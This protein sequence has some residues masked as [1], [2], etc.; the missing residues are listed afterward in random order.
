[1]RIAKIWGFMIFDLKKNAFKIIQIAVALIILLFLL[2]SIDYIQA[3]VSLMHLN[4]IFLLFAC[5]CYFL[6]NI[7]MSIRLKKILKHLG[8]KIRFRIV[9]LSHMAGMLLSDF[10]PGRS[11]YLYVPIALNKKGVPLPAGFAAITSTYIYDLLFKISLAIIAVL[12]LYS[13]LTGLPIGYILYFVVILLLVVIAGY[14]LIMYPGQVIQNFCQKNKYLQYILDMGEQSRSI[15]KMSPYIIFISFLGWVLRGLEWYFV[16]QAIG[17]IDI[18]L[19]E[20]LLLN[21]LL[22]ILSLIPLTPAGLGIQEAGI[23]GILALMGVTLTSATAF[24]FLTRFI[25]ILID[26][27]GLRGFFSLDIKTDALHN[28]Y[29]SID[30]DVDEKAYNSDLYTQRY[31]QR[32]R[33]NTIKKLLD[34]RSNDVI[35]DIGCGSGVQIRALSLERPNLIIG[36]DFNR[37]A[38]LF[39]KRKE[40]SHC[41]FIIAD[42]QRLPFK[43]QTIDK[44]I[45]AEIIEHLNT[46]E[47][48]ISESHRVLKYDGSIVI[49]TPNEY[50]IWGLYEF[51]WDAFG[52]GRNY[53]ETHLRFFS[54]KDLDAYFKSFRTR[55]VLT[56]FF[57]SPFVALSNNRTLVRWSMAF[58]SIFELM[59][60]GVIIVFYAKK[61]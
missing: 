32:R 22:T 23:I 44:I 56:L 15:Q 37:N 45:C 34:A 1:M 25:E 4:W 57:I 13:I 16:A 41:E 38:L 33:T 27:I 3:S 49:T 19:L 30:G 61:K 50:S 17:G 21:P 24:A 60:F 53:G 59:N 14:F 46:P 43:K 47:Q 28:H 58:D 11:G 18:S 29:N 6:N 8:N 42:A 48:L 31:F 35:L 2:G 39:A 26:M 36:M 9:F 20:M 54:V 12:Y 55:S 10:T 40:L 52:R 7:L 5:I 51:L